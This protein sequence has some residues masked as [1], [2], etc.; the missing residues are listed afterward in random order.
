MSEPD[1]SY[2]LEWHL[3]R[4]RARESVRFAGLVKLVNLTRT[5]ARQ[6][7]LAESTE[8]KLISAMYQPTLAEA[9]S[10]VADVLAELCPDPNAA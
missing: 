10:A 5:L 9:F 2:G 4:L 7:R 6:K 8:P 3:E 1:S